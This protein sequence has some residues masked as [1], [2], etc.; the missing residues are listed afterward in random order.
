[1][2][3]QILTKLDFDTSFSFSSLLNDSNS[4]LLLPPRFEELDLNELE[5]VGD[6]G[7]EPSITLF[8]SG[9][10]GLPKKIQLLKSKLRFNISISQQVFGLTSQSKVLIIA[11]PWHVAGLTW[12]A[13]AEASGATFNV[14]TPYVDQLNQIPDLISTFKPTH[15]FT[16]PGALRNFY[17]ASWFVDE[18]IVGGSALVSDDYP[19]L[20]NKTQYLTQAYGQTEAGGLISYIRKNI[21]DYIPNSEFNCVGKPMN[22]IQ[23]ELKGESNHEIWIQS[24]TSTFN[25][26]Y[27]S[28]DLGYF[29]EHGN[30]FITG[31]IASHQ[32]NCN[33]LTGITMVAH[34]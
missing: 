24:P 23:I 19:V 20:M 8:S 1:M 22:G 15:L 7:D 28:G 9:T 25:K 26:T 30:L 10:S 4:Y 31:R 18:I 3:S 14:F 27:F 13:A 17:H 2:N 16:I 33:S 29:D 21:H 5:S 6:V 12:A 32:G 34:K 11:S